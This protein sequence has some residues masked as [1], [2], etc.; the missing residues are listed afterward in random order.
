[1]LMNHGL[2]ECCPT[3]TEYIR[4][5]LDPEGLT[6]STEDPKEVLATFDRCFADEGGSGVTAFEVERYL[7]ALRE[8][9]K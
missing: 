2:C 7:E 6:R 5:H 9:G 3:T 4:Q 8:E 1:M